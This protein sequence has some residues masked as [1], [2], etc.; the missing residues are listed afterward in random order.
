MT[1]MENTS[2]VELAA[3]LKLKTQEKC[4]YEVRNAFGPGGSVCDWWV[5]SGPDGCC[6][7]RFPDALSMVVDCDADIRPHRA[8][9]IVNEL[10]GAGMAL[11]HYEIP[12]P[13]NHHELCP[14]ADVS[15]LL[16][17][18]FN[19]HNEK[20]VELVRKYICDRVVEKNEAQS[21]TER[22]L[23]HINGAVAAT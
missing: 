13:W 11:A 22:W 12:R 8:N 5:G 4:H 15:S 3:K 23:R 10:V 16:V 2:L 1:K 20:H 19:P 7:S 21:A 18:Y 17:F 9:D 6:S 14:N